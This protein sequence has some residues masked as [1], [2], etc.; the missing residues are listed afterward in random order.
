VHA[1][2]V[3]DH[4]GRFRELADAG[5]AE[6]VVRLVDLT[7]PEPLDRMAKIIAAFR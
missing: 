5:A 2:T 4:I 7:D 1:G 3:S 6:V